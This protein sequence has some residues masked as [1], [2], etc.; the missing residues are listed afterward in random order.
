MER[1][2]PLATSAQLLDIAALTLREMQVVMIVLMP[3][4]RSVKTMV[5]LQSNSQTLRD[6]SVRHIR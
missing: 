1:L 4:H 3:M 6:L 2:C 5:E